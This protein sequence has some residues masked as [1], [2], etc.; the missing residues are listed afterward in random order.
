[1]GKDR[2]NNFFGGNK[3]A[4]KKQGGRGYDDE[5]GLS[6]ASDQKQ[7]KARDAR[8]DDYG[9][10]GDEDGLHGGPGDDSEAY[11]PR[12]NAKNLAGG[13]DS[14]SEGEEYGAGAK[15]RN[16][17]GQS[18]KDKSAQRR[19]DGRS[20]GGT[21]KQRRQEPEESDDGGPLPTES[22]EGMDDSDGEANARGRHMLGGQSSKWR[23]RLSVTM[24]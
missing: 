14:E 24:V 1:M 22:Q 16:Q 18:T 17:P 9:S 20:P 13:G 21:S 23:S 19:K 12:A 7:E 4:S 11:Q 3:K 6:S 8:F 10:Y 15:G 2:S 5:D